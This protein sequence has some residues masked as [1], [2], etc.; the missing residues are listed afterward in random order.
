MSDNK[1]L[2]ISIITATRNSGE[3]LR[4]TIESVLRQT[5]SNYEH[6]IVDG[7]SSDDTIAI[8]KEYEPQYGGKL[9]YIS[10]ADKGI[11]DAMN[12]GIGLTTG[13]I[14]GI[15]NSDDFYASSDVLERI[16]E[17]CCDHDS[18]CGDLVF[19]GRND[20]SKIIRHWTGSPYFKNGF[21]KGWH[22]A[23][24]TFYCR[25][26]LF[27]RFGLF[28]INYGPASDFELMLRFIEKNGATVRYIPCVFVKMRYGG[29]STRSIKSIFVG[30][31]HILRAFKKNGYDVSPLY[32]VKRLVSKGW[33]MIRTRG[34]RIYGG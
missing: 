13:D 1:E 19:V 3:T 16:A 10:E 28:D 25:R 32:T 33:N 18:V 7:C 15:L 14:V 8:I 2:R 23:H 4:D 6:I 31:R 22:P 27:E 9:R 12:K 26:Y 17:G 5:Y 24:P 11:Y 29:E 21:L 34:A 20:S 30:N